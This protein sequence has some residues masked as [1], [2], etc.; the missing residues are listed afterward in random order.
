M[1]VRSCDLPLLVWLDIAK[2]L[3]AHSEQTISNIYLMEFESLDKP[4]GNTI[5]L[6]E[7]FFLI[8]FAGK[9]WYKNAKKPKE[10][11]SRWFFF[12]EINLKQSLV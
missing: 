9:D 11:E 7:G 1:A 2:L 5:I 6:K 12:R 8:L 3:F 4:R 10:L